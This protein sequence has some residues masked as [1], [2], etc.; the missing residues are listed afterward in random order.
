MRLTI[1]GKDFAN[2]VVLFLLD[3]LNHPDEVLSG[4]NPSFDAFAEVLNKKGVR[5][6]MTKYYLNLTGQDRVMYKRI[7]G[8]FTENKPPKDVVFDISK[9]DYEEVV[10]KGGI[11]KKIERLVKKFTG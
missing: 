2:I 7:R 6:L 1:E 4:V 8:V 3:K 9:D 5:A 11:F 10:G